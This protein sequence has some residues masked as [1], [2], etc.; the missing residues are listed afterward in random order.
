MVEVCAVA[1]ELA[2]LPVEGAVAWCEALPQESS[3]APDTNRTVTMD[4]RLR[5]QLA[6][7]ATA[8]HMAD[9]HPIHDPLQ[10]TA[11]GVG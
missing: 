7:W 5:N 1:V 6:R 4:A 11:L 2:V 9:V 3:N 10:L 8:Q